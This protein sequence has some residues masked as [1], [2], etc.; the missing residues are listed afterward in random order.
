M[1]TQDQK[2]RA[3][4]TCPKCG[5]ARI[6]LAPDEAPAWA[7]QWTKCYACGKRWNLD[8]GPPKRGTEDAEDRGVHTTRLLPKRTGGD[9]VKLVMDLSRTPPA[10]QTKENA[11]SKCSIASCHDEAADDSVRC[12]THRDQQRAYNAKYQGRAAPKTGNPKQKYTRRNPLGGGTAVSTL[13]AKR[14]SAPITLAEPKIVNATPG[15]RMDLNGNVLTLLDTFIVTL[16]TD[17]ATLRGARE[18]MERSL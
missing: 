5:S 18:I 11:M 12:P 15:R 3:P 17:L 9:L 7:T 4:V 6:A 13:P 16:E 2:T 14:A 10:A 1:E 8:G